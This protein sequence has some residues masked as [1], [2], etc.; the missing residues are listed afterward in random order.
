MHAL[1]KEFP[2]PPLRRFVMAARGKKFVT[3]S[4]PAFIARTAFGQILERVSGH[5]QRF[6]VTKH[7]EAKAIMLG[8]E[9][10]LQAV[11]KIPPELAAIQAEAKKRGVDTLTL[12]EIAAE[13][14]AVRQTKRRPRH[15]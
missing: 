7:G 2:R 9:D 1:I 3:K 10:F 5:R 6:V 15:A 14:Q 11:V 4:V 8:V 12:E 13:I